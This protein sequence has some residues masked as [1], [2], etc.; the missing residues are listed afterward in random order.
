[1]FIP[2]LKSCSFQSILLFLILLHMFGG[3][4]ISLIMFSLMIL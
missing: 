2:S 4:V 1:M 3:K